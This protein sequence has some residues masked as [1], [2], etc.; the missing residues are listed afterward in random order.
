MDL[1]GQNGIVHCEF[2]PQWTLCAWKAS[3][4]S[5]VRTSTVKKDSVNSHCSKPSATRQS[6]LRPCGISP[7]V[8]EAS[9]HAEPTVA[10]HDLTVDTRGLANCVTLATHTHRRMRCAPTAQRI[11]SHS[12]ANQHDSHVQTDKIPTNDSQFSHDS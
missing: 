2:I 10:T 6:A 8:F 1:P 11:D 4:R 12:V 9:T 3:E 5:Q 7:T